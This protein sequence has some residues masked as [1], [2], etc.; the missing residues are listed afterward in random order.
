MRLHEKEREPLRRSFLKPKDNGK[1]TICKGK[2]SDAA[3]KE[4][5]ICSVRC[6]W[7]KLNFREFNISRFTMLCLREGCQAMAGIT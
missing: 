1:Y 4:N 3:D 2:Y 5:I 6:I 7:R